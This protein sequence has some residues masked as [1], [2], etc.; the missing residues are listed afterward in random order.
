M[1]ES[2]PN[3]LDADEN[4][5]KNAVGVAGDREETAMDSGEDDASWIKI[6]QKV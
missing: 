6:E 1:K 3:S 4:T 2:K 5:Q